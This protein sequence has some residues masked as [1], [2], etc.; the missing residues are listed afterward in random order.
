M[1]IYE[2]N[3]F[4]PTCFTE[5]AEAIVQLSSFS[6]LFF[7]VLGRLIGLITVFDAILT[8]RQTGLK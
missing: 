2:Q 6:R 4:K 3:L 1:A 7:V 5:A 8:S